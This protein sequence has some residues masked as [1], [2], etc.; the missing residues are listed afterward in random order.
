MLRAR[1]SVV[2]VFYVCDEKTFFFF[3]LNPCSRRLIFLVVVDWEFIHRLDCSYNPFGFSFYSFCIL[4][5]LIFMAP[6]APHPNHTTGYIHTIY[7]PNLP[8]NNF[9]RG[10][11]FHRISTL[12]TKTKKQNPP[13]KNN[14]IIRKKV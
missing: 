6:P 12:N 7:Q 3:F 10:S 8:T 11:G 5:F 14:L 1:V 2:C 13:K 4:F 9:P